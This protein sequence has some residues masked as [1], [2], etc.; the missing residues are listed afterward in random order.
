MRTAAIGTSSA[1]RLR[2]WRTVSGRIWLN[3]EDTLGGLDGQSRNAG[4]GIASKGGGGFHVRGDSSPR[5]RIESCD[6]QDN[7][8]RGH[9]K[10]VPQRATQCSILMVPQVPPCFDRKSTVTVLSYK[11]LPI[12]IVTA[13]Q[14]EEAALESSTAPHSVV[15]LGPRR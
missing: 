4:H 9:A 7:W 8:A 11:Y 6:A 15:G 5:R 10:N 14:A 3:P 1:N 12:D 2:V 13:Q